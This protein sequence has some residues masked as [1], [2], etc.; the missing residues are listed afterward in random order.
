MK[1]LIL[2]LIFSLLFLMLIKISIAQPPEPPPE[3]PQIGGDNTTATSSDQTTATNTKEEEVLLNKDQDLKKESISIIE[4]PGKNN[5]LLTF[6]L[7]LNFVLIILI[8]IFLVL[9]LR[10]RKMTLNNNVQKP[11]NYLREDIDIIKLKNYIKNSL[12][13]GHNQESIKQILLRNNWPEEKINQDL[14]E[15]KYG[16]GRAF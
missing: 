11:N 9:W 4:E 7:S 15:V 3:P 16:S 6:S 2:I 14:N 12:N 10:K 5:F 8:I 1:K 13:Q